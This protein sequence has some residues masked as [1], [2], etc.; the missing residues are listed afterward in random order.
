MHACNSTLLYPK[1]QAIL[2]TSKWF[3]MLSCKIPLIFSEGS[4]IANYSPKRCVNKEKYLISHHFTKF[5]D[6]VVPTVNEAVDFLGKRNLIWKT[7]E[8]EQNEIRIFSTVLNSASQP[9]EKKKNK[10]HIRNNFYWICSTFND[11]IKI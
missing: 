9:F 6:S 10:Q 11:K 5:D 3:K 7:L 4:V 8:L 2:F 1:S